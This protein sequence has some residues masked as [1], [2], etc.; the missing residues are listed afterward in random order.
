MHIIFFVVGQQHSC[1]S[2]FNAYR[3]AETFMM[4]HLH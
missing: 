3:G 2:A 4:E 1:S